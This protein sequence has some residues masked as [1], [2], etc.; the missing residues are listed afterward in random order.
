ML[1]DAGRSRIAV[2]DHGVVGVV[3]VFAI[4]R[5]QRGALMVRVGRGEEWLKPGRGNLAESG[6]EMAGEMAGETFL[7]V[8]PVSSTIRPLTCT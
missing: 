1:S 6:G 4:D 7:S 3:G 2:S 8:C 5:E